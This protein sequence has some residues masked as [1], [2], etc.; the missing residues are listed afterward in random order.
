MHYINNRRLDQLL[1]LGRLTDTCEPARASPEALGCPGFDEGE[2]WTSLP[3]ERGDRD[4]TKR[5]A[6][7]VPAPCQDLLT[8][9]MFVADEILEQL[10]SDDLVALAR[11]VV[12]V[13]EVLFDAPHVEV[14]DVFVRVPAS[15]EK[16][17]VLGIV[18]D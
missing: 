1:S 15:P 17:E 18:E 8:L 12:L 9:T 4:G 14:V 16:L 7:G 2:Y 13:P 11:E 5:L 10:L 3:S 6:A